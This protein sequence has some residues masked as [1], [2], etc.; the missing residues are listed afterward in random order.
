MKNKIIILIFLV[1]ISLFNYKS[2]SLTKKNTNLINEVLSSVQGNTVEY[3]IRATFEINDNGEKYCLELLKKL[4][5]TDNDI[6]IVKSDKFY[7]LD[8]NK[9][10]TKGYIEY[11]SYDNH[12]VVTINM[13]KVDNMNR[14][15]EFKETIEK[16]INKTEKDVKYFQFLK[17]KVIENDKLKLN[18]KIIEVLKTEKAENIYSVQFNNGISTVAYTKQ[19]DAM[20]NNGKLMDFNFSLCSYSSGNYLIIGTPIIIEAY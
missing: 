1:I 15:E 10:E 17:A 11:S 12:N 6:N 2:F 5:L 9:N 7:S 13:I 20:K 16:A 19:F 18:N 8:F 4:N 3:G 14:L